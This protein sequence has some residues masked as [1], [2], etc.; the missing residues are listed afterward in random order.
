[1]VPSLSIDKPNGSNGHFERRP[2]AVAFVDIVGYSALMAA[3]ED[4]THAQWM[5]IRRQIIEEK[6]DRHN[7]NFVKSTGDGV[8]AE[9]TSAL[10]AVAW[11]RDVQAALRAYDAPLVPKLELRIA[12]HLCD[13]IDD[14]SDIYGDGVN[15]AAR[16]QTFAPPG[17]IVVSE[18]VYDIARVSIDLDAKD[19]GLL[20]LKNMSRPVRAYVIDPDLVDIGRAKDRREEVLPSIAVLPMRNLS[21]RQSDSYFGYGIVEDIVISLAG[22]RELLVIS[23]GST[24]AYA[25]QDQDP[26]HVGLAFGVR[27]VL[28]GTVRRSRRKVRISVELC[29][30]ETGHHLW[31]D[32]YTVPVEDLFDV[33]DDIVERVVAGIA[34]N[35]RAVELRQAMRKRP[36]NFTA[37]DHTLR[38]LGCIHSLECETFMTARDH[39]DQALCIDPE[40]AMAVAWKARWYSLLIGQGWSTNPAEDAVSVGTLAERAIRSDP[41]NALALATFGHMKSYLFHDLDTAKVYLD[42]ALDACPSSASAWFFSSACLSYLGQAEEAVRY[43]EKAIR[44]SPYDH[45]LFYSYFCLGLAHY[46]GGSYEEAVKWCRMSY[47]E[48]SKFTANLRLLAV[49]LAAAGNVAESQ[50]AVAILMEMEPDFTISN[51][52]R[53]RQPFAEEKIRKK[54]LEDLR[55]AGFP[56]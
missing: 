4:R 34:P 20:P 48:N 29:E 8:L 28:R 44:L 52:M 26:H 10:E 19:L 3:D 7:G 50:K 53:T 27:Y 24:L 15:I 6:L 11:A 13:I 5:I 12:I 9:F 23:R 49:S 41:Q 31:A 22:L 56:D 35:V 46:G 18:V 42:R 36:E 1:M 43:A 54:V 17:G 30:A 25:A 14:E 16:L 39:L 45:S 47:A 37:Y 33:Q 40:F 32:T 2:V 51:Y 55:T 21:G 38:A